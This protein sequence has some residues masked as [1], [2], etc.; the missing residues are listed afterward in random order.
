MSIYKLRTEMGHYFKWLLLF[1]LVPIFVIGGANYFG[2]GEAGGRLAVGIDDNCAV[3][4]QIYFRGFCDMA[5][6]TAVAD[7][8]TYVIAHDPASAVSGVLM[9]TVAEA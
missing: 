5:G 9:I 7:P 8:L 1:V 2:S 6:V 3:F 4:H